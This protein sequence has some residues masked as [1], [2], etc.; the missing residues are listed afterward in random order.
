[1]KKLKLNF[2]ELNNAEV[3]TRVQ[4]K[5]ILGG[6]DGSGKILCYCDGI[7]P[8]GQYATQWIADSCATA[9]IAGHCG[10]ASAGTCG[11]CS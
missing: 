11:A 3:L 10:S 1:M 8:N 5:K 4:L 2:E 7:L 6:T 9:D